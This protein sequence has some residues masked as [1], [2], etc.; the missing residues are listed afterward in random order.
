MMLKKT[1]QGMSAIGMLII[2]FLAILVLLFVIK[3]VPIYLESFEMDTVFE[4][5]KADDTLRGK[6]TKEI[7]KSIGKRM[8]INSI[9]EPALDEIEILKTP[10]GIQVSVEYEVETGFMGNIFLVLKFSKEVILN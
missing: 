1:Q 3:I 2:A 8:N 6:P 7:R 10:E 5:L 9:E 4:G